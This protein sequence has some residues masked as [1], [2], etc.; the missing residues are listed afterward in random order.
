MLIYG[1]TEHYEAE[2]DHC[3][4]NKPFQWMSLLLLISRSSIMLS[5]QPLQIFFAPINDLLRKE[6]AHTRCS[7]TLPWKSLPN[8]CYRVTD[9][10][11]SGC[12][13]HSS[14]YQPQK[15]A[16]VQSC[17]NFFI[18]Y[19]FLVTFVLLVHERSTDGSISLNELSF[20]MSFKCM[21]LYVPL[22]C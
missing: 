11:M 20:L 13:Q 19:F 15:V 7:E 18:L 3:Q 9:R 10:L 1:L 17:Q 6:A 8:N 4:Q 21:S 16:M 5:H 14:Q 22:S 12:F 2:R